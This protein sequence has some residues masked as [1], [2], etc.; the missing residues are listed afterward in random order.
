MLAVMYSPAMR[1]PYIASIVTMK[2]M[3]GRTGTHGVERK[4]T[5]LNH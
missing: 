4:N 1:F 2:T 3:N 5:P